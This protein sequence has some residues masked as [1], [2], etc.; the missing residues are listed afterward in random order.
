MKKSLLAVALFSFMLVPFSLI[1]QNKKAGVTGKILDPQGKPLVR[2]EVGLRSVLSGIAQTI[3]T[4]DSGEYSFTNITPGDYILTASASGLTTQ[5]RS[6]QVKPEATVHAPDIT[7]PLA[8]VQQSITVVS[9]SRVEELQQDSPLP[10]EAVSSQHIKRTGY[11]NVGDVLSELPGVVTRDNASFSGAAEEQIDGI[12]SQDILVLQ[13]GLP[14]VGAR[15]IKSGILDLDQQ[16]IGKLDQ[17]EV[18]RGAASSLYG[19]DAVGGV[20]NM[21]THEPTQTFELGARTSGG[22][23]GA[24]DNGLTLGTKWN[25]LS[26]FTDLE[27]HRIGSYSLIPGDES[28]IGADEQRYDGFLKVRYSFTPG[29]SLGFK[30]SAYHNDAT[31]KST[32]FFGLGTSGYDHAISRD[33]T[34]DYALVGDFLPTHTTAIQARLYEARYD[35]NSYENPIASDGSLGDP[36]DAGNLYER[37]HR[38]DATISQQLGSWQ[39]LQGGDEWVQDQYRGLNRLVG[40][41]AGQQITTNDVWLQDR[42]Q[43][44]RRLTI[45]LGGRYNHNSLYGSHLVPKAGA[46]YRISDHWTARASYGKGFRAPTVGE[47]YYLL[48]HP[49]FG[50]QVIGNPTLQPERSESYS[51]GTDYQVNRYNFGVTLYRNNL[52][53]LI[54][55]IFAGFPAEETDLEALLAQY[56][57]PSSFGGQ[58]GLA[59]YIYNNV[60]QAYTRGINLKAGVL[61][62][63]NL[64]VDGAY[65]YLDPYDTINHQTVV[66]C[67]HNQGYFKTEYVLNRWGLITN[68]RGN[69]FG[70]WLIDPTQGTHESAYSIWNFYLSKDLRYGLQMYGAINNLNNSRDALLAQTPPT[71]DRTDYGR[72]FRIGMHYTFARE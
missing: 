1:A 68:I 3:Q 7:L 47:L 17:V 52:N 60:D 19:T 15:G 9:A 39:F 43:P 20:I 51:F 63:R 61:I 18:V 16:D 42:I 50:Y 36:F 29:A 62:T 10:I 28:T 5:N 23:L 11:E 2:A 71:Y 67:S 35:E 25:K 21:I 49:E 8:A 58:P 26:A 34:Q 54:N 48:E 12:A 24:F 65:G 4:D 40:D 14:I 66:E 44:L 69:F 33:S 30:T 59:T 57:V 46:V 55:F 32:D 22:T 31:G 64:R 45:T 72:T 41:D 56:G 27:S 38:A 37:Y 53:N 6:I 13:D 70:R